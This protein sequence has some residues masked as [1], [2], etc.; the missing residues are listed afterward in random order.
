[1]PLNLNISPFI[2]IGYGFDGRGMD[3][4]LLVGSRDFRI[5]RGVQINYWV[6]PGR[7]Q[8]GHSSHGGT[9]A[10]GYVS[11]LHLVMR[12]RTDGGLSISPTSS[13]PGT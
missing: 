6:H 11:R 1:M 4:R 12:L 5:L 7:R 13:Q 3:F 2:G 9:G 8:G 10:R